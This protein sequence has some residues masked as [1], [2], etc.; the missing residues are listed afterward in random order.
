MKLEGYDKKPN[1]TYFEK[2]DGQI[3]PL[4]VYFLT[5][6]IMNIH[7]KLATTGDAIHI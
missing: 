5:N 1:Y 7:L 2:Q 4:D 6:R 3:F